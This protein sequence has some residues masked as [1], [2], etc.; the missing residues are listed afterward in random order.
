MLLESELFGAVKGAYTG[1]DRNRVGLFEAANGGTLLLDEIA[2]LSAALQPK[3][4]RVLQNG[5][6]FRLGDPTR[7]IRVDVRVLASTNRD[8]SEALKT[9]AFRSDLYCR[10]SETRGT[11]PQDPQERRGSRRGC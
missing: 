5:E 8:L 1:S 6:F 11:D 7:A 2:E 3:L 9:G 4:L 10:R